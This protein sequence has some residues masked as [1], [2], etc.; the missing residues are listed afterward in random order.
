MRMKSIKAVKKG[1]AVRKKP[2]EKEKA[3]DAKN[4]ADSL[5]FQT[6]KGNRRAGR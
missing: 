2:T 3:I 4:E 5:I 6:E 1:R